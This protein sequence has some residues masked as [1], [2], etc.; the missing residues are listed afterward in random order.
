[1]KHRVA[2]GGK[3]AAPKAMKIIAALVMSS[4]TAA[5]LAEAPPDSSGRA[6]DPVTAVSVVERFIQ[7]SGGPELA[8]VKTEKR[9]GTLIRGV[10]GQVP[11]ETI[12]AASGAWLYS[13]V[14]AYGDRV[15]YGFDGV[16]AWVQDAGGTAVMPPVER[17]ELSLLLDIQAPLKLGRLFP[18]M[19]VK[20]REKVGER[21]AVVLEV[22]SE[23]GLGSELAF[24]RVTGLLLRAGDLFFED[25]RD[26]GGVKRPFVVFFGKADIQPPLRLKMQA[27][28]ITRDVEVE[29]SVFA[30]PTCALSPGPPVLYKLRKEIP[31]SQESLEAL[32]GVYQLNADPKVQFTVTTQGPHLMIER[33]GWGF[34]VEIL[35]ESPTDYFMRFLNREFHFVKDAAGRVTGFEMGPDRVQKATRIK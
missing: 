34:R 25:Y 12:S 3:N 20:G 18:R 17:L 1:M 8:K 15:S 27:A 30:R 7:A 14:F 24:D 33:T 10:S 35:P 31:V 21:E 16:R 26:V 19:T 32:V 29:A 9:Q 5:V 13:Q 6:Q 23:E 2:S 11:F 4:V 28:E 22:L